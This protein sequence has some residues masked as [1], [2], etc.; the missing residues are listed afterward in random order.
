[1]Y[2][3]EGDALPRNVSEGMVM[4]VGSLLRATWRRLRTATAS[5]KPEQ[6]AER[7]GLTVNLALRASITYF[8]SESMLFPNDPRF[9]GKAIPIR[10]VIIVTSL[11]A[12]LPAMQVWR[13]RWRRY[14][15]WLDNLYL[16]IFWLDMLG[17]S[18]DLYDRY[19]YFDLIPHAHGPGAASIVFREALGLSPL[20]AV[21][22]TSILHTLLE[23]QEYYTDVFFGTRNVRGVFDT[24]NDLLA[25]V[26][27]STAYMTLY[28]VA[29]RP[30]VGRVD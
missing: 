29:R 23:G 26:A 5:F 15:Y 16:S 3:E 4:G 27:G 21:G 28:I 14:P 13:R 10:N 2:Y 11:S 20:G 6:P 12:A 17:N 30:R 25:G 7:L 9:A 1:M 22:L 24:I 18:L 19:F 8:L